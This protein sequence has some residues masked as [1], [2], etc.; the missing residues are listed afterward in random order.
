MY[1]VLNTPKPENTAVEHHASIHRVKL[2][3]TVYH[4]ISTYNGS[5]YTIE[6]VKTGCNCIKVKDINNTSNED[7]KG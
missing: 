6:N 1:S 3:V 7:T 4:T 2:R 5:R